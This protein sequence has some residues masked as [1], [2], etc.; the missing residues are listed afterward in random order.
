VERDAKTGFVRVDDRMETSAPGIFAVGDVC[1]PPML[2][3]KAY[4]E[5]IV[6]AEA[7][8]GRPTRFSFQ[9]MPAVVFTTPELASVGLAVSDARERGYPN[10]REARFP[11]AAL[12]RAHA[13]HA[14]EGWTKLVADGETE[15][16][17]GGHAAGAAA[18]EYVTEIGFAI[19]TAAR[20]RDLAETVH[21]HPTFSETVQE[22]ARLW[23]NEP[24]HVATRK[25][26]DARPA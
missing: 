13:A 18:G 23:L 22:V 10:A 6:A 21:P 4:R 8:A 2:A 25:A 11:Y 14:T 3:H 12:G 19:E 26:R 16:V 9:A 17:L 1:R 7:I 5:G 15:L 20:V 24:L